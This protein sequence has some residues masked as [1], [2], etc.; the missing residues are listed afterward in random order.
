M[1][2][3]IFEGHANRKFGGAEMSMAEFI[4]DCQLK[5]IET[6]VVCEE[7]VDFPGK[8]ALVGK[9]PSLRSPLASLRWVWR[10]C[11]IVVDNRPNVI[12]THCTHCLFQ[13]SVIAFLR[14][15]PVRVYFKWVPANRDVPRHYA[16]LRHLG[17]QISCNSESVKIFWEE[18]LKIKGDF[19]YDGISRKDLRPIT[20][21]SVAN[22]TRFHVCYVG[23]VNEQ[24]GVILLLQALLRKQNFRLTIVGKSSES[25]HK[26]LRGLIAESKVVDLVDLVGF[27]DDP[28]SLIQEADLMICPS[29]VQDSA[30][31]SVMEGMMAGL[32]VAVSSLVGMKAE[33]GPLQSRLIFSP[34]VEGIT[35]VIDSVQS[36]DSSARSELIH[37]QEL[38]FQENFLFSRTLQ[39]LHSFVS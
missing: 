34:S 26:K 27:S 2:I 1:K 15:I 35:R 11:Q 14:N 9:T 5:G 38:T 31:R 39:K 32:P 37:E 20:G 18:K 4:D 29:I 33:F 6:V 28:I 7:Y 36:M 13:L 8:H 16:L 22:S 30:P 24:K 19:F 10:L 23:R 21:L 25:F 17:I 12:L 3:L